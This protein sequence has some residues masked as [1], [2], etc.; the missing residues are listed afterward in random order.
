LNRDVNSICV[1]PA[2]DVPDHKVASAI[3]DR[4]RM[5][6]MAKRV[7]DLLDVD[8]LEVLVI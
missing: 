8:D 4:D 5:S 3:T 7:K 6:I 2:K 1:E